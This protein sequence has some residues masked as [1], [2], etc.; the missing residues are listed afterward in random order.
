MKRPPKV[1]IA[2]PKNRPF[3]LRYTCPEEGREVRMSTGTRDEKKAQQQ[4]EQLEAKLLLGID[5]KPKRVERG[6][7]MK[8][9]DFRHDYTRLKVST[10]RSEKA[11]DV[12]EICLDLCESIIS[13]R[14]LNDMA[15]PETLSRLQAELLAG[16]NSRRKRRRSP[17]TVESYMR[18]LQ[19]ALNWGHKMGW[20]A[21]KVTLDLLDVDDDSETFKGRPLI[22]D[23]FESMLAA[24]QVVSPDGSETWQF[25]LRG[26]WESGLRLGEVM[27]LSWDDDARIRPLKTRGGGY[28]LKIPSKQKKS[29]K[30]QEVPTIPAFAELLDEVH[31]EDRTGWIFNPAPL[32]RWPRR[33]SEPQAGRIITRIGTEAG[34]VVNE[35]GKFASAHDLRR[36][37][38]QR[39][40]DAGLPPRDLQAIMRHSSLATTEKYY[41]RHRAI[42]QAERIA[43]HL[44]TSEERQKKTAHD[45]SSQTVVR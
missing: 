44:G 23:E 37:F 7:R 35:H 39:M 6:P 32:R 14:V 11:M 9:E 18:T 24:C 43:A 4:K 2:R 1:R 19:A 34:I 25:L 29:R 3:Q 27:N 40:A 5:A 10:F 26:L 20:L 45:E 22:V 31:N 13:P 28:L 17:H 38:G 16:S 21:D 42:D 12:A 30:A 41:L 36:S 15:S 33:L 8:W